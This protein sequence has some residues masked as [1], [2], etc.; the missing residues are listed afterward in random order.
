[1]AHDADEMHDLE[2]A[3]WLHDIRLLMLPPHLVESRDSPEPECYV[4]IQ[5]HIP[6]RSDS[7][8]TLFFLEG[9]SILIA[10]HHEC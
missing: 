4:P 5:N 10:H 7:A 6:A 8:R 2:L 3:V 9:A 1:M